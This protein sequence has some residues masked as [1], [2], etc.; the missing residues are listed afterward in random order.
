MSTKRRRKDAPTTEQQ[1]IDGRRAGGEAGRELRGLARV[2]WEASPDASWAEVAAEA[3]ER[4]ALHP[5]V[6]E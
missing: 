1:R 6:D 2:I 4:G 3:R 5:G